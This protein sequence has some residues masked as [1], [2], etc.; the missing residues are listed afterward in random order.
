M[1]WI[2]TQ[3]FKVFG[4]TSNIDLKNRKWIFEKI[5]RRRITFIH[6]IIRRVCS[7]RFFVF[8]LAMK[9]LPGGPETVTQYHNF[10]N[11]Y[12]IILLAIVDPWYYFIWDSFICLFY[13]FIYFF[14]LFYLLVP[15]ATLMTRFFSNQLDYGKK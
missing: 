5:L 6:F 12:S 11:I 9:F 4:H 3:L 10:K 7:Y 14:G 2:F 15:K 8:C 13:L 1:W